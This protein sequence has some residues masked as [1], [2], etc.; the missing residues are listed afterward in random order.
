MATPKSKRTTKN[1]SKVVGRQTYI[2][3]DT[4]EWCEF[5]VI[6]MKSTDFNFKKIWLQHILTSFDLIGNKKTKLAFFV[7][8]SM[9][10]ENVITMTYQQMADKSGI[11][12][13]TVKETMKMLIK[14]D[15]LQRIN[16]GAYRINPDM[17]FRGDNP[18]RMRVLLDYKHEIGDESESIMALTEFTENSNTEATETESG[19]AASGKE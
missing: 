19:K 2:N 7:I 18:K 1:K 17:I 3:N 11:S 10:Y 8:D 4:G 14:S 12:L 15:F 13:P 9:N 5:D 6:E 16:Q